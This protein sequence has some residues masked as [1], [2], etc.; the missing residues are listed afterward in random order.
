MRSRTRRRCAR[1]PCGCREGKRRVPA[2]FQTLPAGAYSTA[3]AC[4]VAR[5]PCRCLRVL[6][7]RR[8]TSPPTVQYDID[9]IH[10]DSAGYPSP[11]YLPCRQAAIY[12][13]ALAEIAA[14]AS[15][16]PCMYIEYLPLPRCCASCSIH[17]FCRHLPSHNC[18]LV[19]AH[20]WSPSPTAA[21]QPAEEPLP[22]VCLA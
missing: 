13:L 22:P 12:D 11:Q 2:R 7:V 21:P 3:W 20:L 16:I 18:P 14:E 5:L 19:R 1:E 6:R 8:G 9:I 15:R 10:V 4:S 17:S